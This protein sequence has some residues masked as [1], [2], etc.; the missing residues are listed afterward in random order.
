[1]VREA[2]ASSAISSWELI[3]ITPVPLAER[4]AGETIVISPL[5]NAGEISKNVYDTSSYLK[6]VQQIFGIEEELLP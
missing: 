4:W 6:T 5:A 2:P 1:M 3:A